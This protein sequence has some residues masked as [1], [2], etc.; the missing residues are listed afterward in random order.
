M[1]H[2]LV[3]QVAAC[4]LDDGVLAM[5]G[6][7]GLQWVGSIGDEREVAPV[8]PELGLGADQPG[9]TNDQPPSVRVVC[10]NLRLSL[11]GVVPKGCQEDSG[12]CLIASGTQNCRRTLIE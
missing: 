12:I 11:L 4:Q 5:L 6:L 7:D 9:A 10:A 2:S 1:R 8:R 3:L